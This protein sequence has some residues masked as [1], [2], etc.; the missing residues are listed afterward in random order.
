M[1]NKLSKNLKDKIYRRNSIPGPVSSKSVASAVDFLISDNSKS[2][3]GQTI[4]IDNG[5]F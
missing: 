5:A 3:T 1:T 4:L 2:I